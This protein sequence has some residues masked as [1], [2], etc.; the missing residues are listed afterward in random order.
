[1]TNYIFSGLGQ[2]TGRYNVSTKDIKEAIDKGLLS[3][4]D[5]SKILRSKNYQKFLITHPGTSAFEYFAN[6]KMGFENRSYVI[7]FPPKKKHFLPTETS[8]DLAVRAIEDALND[9]G[10]D[11]EKIDAW[12]VSTVSPHEQAP[13]IAA[14]VKAH[15]VGFDNKTP[16]YTLTSGCAGFHTNLERAIEYLNEN[17]NAR[18][19]VV[20]HTETMS[21]FLTEKSLF[22]SFVTFGDAAG[23][24]VLTK[25]QS[26]KKEGV[27]RIENYQDLQMVDF[28]GVDKNWNLYM[29][30]LVIKNRAVVNIVNSTKWILEKENLQINDID[31]FVP[32]QTGN[33][34]LLEAAK[35]LNVIPQ[36]LYLDVQRRFG[37]V[38]GATV[39]LS[40]SMLN[41]ELRLYK[42]QKILSSAAGVGGKYGAFLYIVPEKTEKKTAKPKAFAGKTAFVVGATGSIGKGI[43]VKLAKENCKLILHYKDDSKKE[44]L[45]KELSKYNTE[46]KWVKFDLSKLNEVES[47]I[48]KLSDTKINY[49]ILAGGVSGGLRKVEEISIDEYEKINT[50]NFTSQTVIVKKLLA[51]ISETVLYLGSAAED[52]Q[53]AGSS[54]YVASKKALHGYA[55]SISG[56]A[57]SKGIRSVYFMPGV[58]NGGMTSQLNE[59]Q[60]FQAMQA[61]NQTQILELDTLT[62]KIL[63]SLYLLKVTAVTESFENMLTVRRFGYYL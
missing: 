9:A 23:A 56:E 45:Q 49:L 28:V 33:A 58:V 30:E 59:K 4:F 19:V 50:I 55:A 27:I 40:L 48:E 31:L 13:G 21:S 44:N 62:D 16:T 24:V 7:P 5:E 32:H 22:V 15:F 1:M 61:I 36:K 14:T 51:N 20:C 29:D 42:G 54:A 35:E 26:D 2:A 37:N 39:P 57:F 10:Q 38:S 17:E 60:I 18:N 46:I 43:A 8:T 3:G 12:F 47:E 11:A 6:Y 53:F 63:K 41:K 25:T 34:I 52:A